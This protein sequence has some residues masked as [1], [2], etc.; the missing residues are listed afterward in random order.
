MSG[1][2]DM[3]I[4]RWVEEAPQDFVSWLLHDAIFE[5]EAQSELQNT[6]VDRGRVARI[7]PRAWIARVY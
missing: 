2:W 3:M 5:H 6:K 7:T 4:K 1:P